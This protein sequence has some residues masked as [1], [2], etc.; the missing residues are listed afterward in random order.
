MKEEGQN[1]VVTVQNKK[2]VGDEDGGVPVDQRM[3]KLGT[4]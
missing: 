1:N 2:G 4:A 3:N